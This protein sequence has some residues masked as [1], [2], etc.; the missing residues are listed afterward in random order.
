MGIGLFLF[1]VLSYAIAFVLWGTSLL[2]AVH[3]HGLLSGHLW[4]PLAWIAAGAGFILALIFQVGVLHRLLPR[5]RPGSYTLLKEPMFFYWTARMI[6]RRTLLPPFLDT[7][8]FQSNVLRYLALRALG[9]RVSF[10]TSMSS[11]VV[12]LDPWL[13]EAGPGAV[14]GTG[15]MASGH[16]VDGDKLKLGKIV[17]EQDALVAAQCIL[18]PGVHIGA[19]ARVLPRAV[20]G[21]DV[22]LG[23][24]AVLG[25]NT[26]IERGVRIGPGVR[27]GTMSYVHKNMEITHDVP[28]CSTLGL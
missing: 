1:D 26:G 28:P 17:V 16:F 22:T 10:S 24:G 7:F 27:V 9:A 2:A 21:V 13:F 19:R 4:A 18:A 12:L 23:E 11:D 5:V 14:L 20:L 3:V 25:V 6:L 15:T 8:I